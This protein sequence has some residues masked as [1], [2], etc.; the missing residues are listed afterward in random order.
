[1]SFLI[2]WLSLDDFFNENCGEKYLREE[3]GLQ[4]GGLHTWKNRNNTEK[5]SVNQVKLDLIA[6]ELRRGAPLERVDVRGS[7]LQIGDEKWER[8]KGQNNK[9]R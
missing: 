1:M 6:N 7:T 8:Q 4:R 5:N 2:D 3:W 9:T